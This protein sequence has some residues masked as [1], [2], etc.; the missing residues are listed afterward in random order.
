M[1]MGLHIREVEKGDNASLALMIRQVFE[2]YD[3]PREG[4]V[5]TDPTTDD[6]F[7]L[8]QGAESMLWVAEWHG[9]AVG[10]CGI[11]P[12]PGLDKGF[13]EL[14]KFYLAAPARGKGIGK[15]L[16]ER[17]LS[18]ARELGYTRLYLESMPEFSKALGIY[19]HLGF[20]S[21]VGP[22]GNSGHTGCKIWM[23]KE[24]YGLP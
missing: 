11:Y 12:T 3:A 24:L 23:I 21:L 4:T 5:Y 1:E 18:S 17:S 8:F 15:A 7:S 22:L 20:R 6:L 19:E 13:A 14:V 10:C 2:E 9:K 16:L